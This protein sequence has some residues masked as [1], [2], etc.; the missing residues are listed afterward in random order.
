[1]PAGE[2]RNGL[3]I[4]LADGLKPIKNYLAQA[5]DIIQAYK[6]SFLLIP[7]SVLGFPSQH[8]PFLENAVW[9]CVGSVGKGAGTYKFLI[10]SLQQEPGQMMPS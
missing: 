4:Q 10:V 5:W 6:N 8:P 7:Q 9:F 1:M 3:W 2:G